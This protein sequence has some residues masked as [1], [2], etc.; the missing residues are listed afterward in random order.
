MVKLFIFIYGWI[1]IRGFV[2]FYFQAISNASF[3]VALPIL[4][5]NLVFVKEKFYS[6][7]IPFIHITI[8]IFQYQVEGLE[9]IQNSN[10]LSFN[11]RSSLI[12]IWYSNN[13]N[14]LNNAYLF[15]ND[16][17][18]WGQRTTSLI[19]L[20]LRISNLKYMMLSEKGL[21]MIEALVFND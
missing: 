3:E 7:S 9:Y 13:L 14:S 5:L 15:H 17:I 1:M 20:F 6:L 18:N 16:K 19:T 8:I 4:T 2:F 11:K 12:L 21:I 10:L